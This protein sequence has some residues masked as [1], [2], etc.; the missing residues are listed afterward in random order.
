[1]RHL[2][3]VTFHLLDCFSVVL[4]FVCK[5]GDFVVLVGDQLLIGFHSIL[6]V[7]IILSWNGRVKEDFL[8]IGNLLQ[9]FHFFE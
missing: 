6:L 4:Q 5:V 7:F 9:L 1:M 8:L 3:L 2:F